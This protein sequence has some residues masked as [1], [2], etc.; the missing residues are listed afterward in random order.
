MNA[1]RELDAWIAERVMDLRVTVNEDNAWLA[2]DSLVVVGEQGAHVL[3]HYSTDIAAAWLVVEWVKRT[4]NIT[5]QVLPY[6]VWVELHIV[7]PV[8]AKSGGDID[9]NT[10]FRHA[11][12]SAPTAPLAICLAAR[13]TVAWS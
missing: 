4:G 10:G 9:P 3:P 5:I 6:A 11:V 12:V 8:V 1:G 13:K 7:D 2:G